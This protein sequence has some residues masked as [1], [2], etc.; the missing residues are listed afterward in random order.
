M[1]PCSL[2]VDLLIWEHCRESFFS[3]CYHSS[4]LGISFL[5]SEQKSMWRC[6]MVCSVGLKEETSHRI[7]LRSESFRSDSWSHEDVSPDEN[8]GFTEMVRM[9]LNLSNI[10]GIKLLH[11][12]SKEDPVPRVCPYSHFLFPPYLP[13][14]YRL[15]GV[16]SF[17]P[18]WRFISWIDSLTLVNFIY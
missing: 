11:R 9:Y 16:L 17:A 18:L 1:L 2:S 12:F 5:L 14:A 6:L 7:Q 13:W 8:I 3:S 15:P 10:P 4:D